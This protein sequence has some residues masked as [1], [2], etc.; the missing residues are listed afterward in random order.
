[1]VA[2]A[3]IL[4][5]PINS[6]AGGSGI[7]GLTTTT[8]NGQPMLTLEDTTRA[9]KILS[10]GEQVFIFAEN[11]LSNLDWIRVANANDADSGFVADFNGTIV[12]ISAH[13]ENTGANSKDIRLFIDA[14][15]SGVLGT[16]SGG[17]NATVNDTTLDIDF[18]Q[19][20]RVRLRADD[21]IAGNIQDTIVKLTVKWRG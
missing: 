14:V 11:Q 12:N 15:D 13:C 4:T 8:I 21:G 10:V 7:T 6:G 16:L 18:N 2:D 17:A 19:G 3:I 1:M 5:R 20:Q 9:N